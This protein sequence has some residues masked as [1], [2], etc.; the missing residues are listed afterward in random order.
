MKCSGKFYGMQ[1]L[2]PI[3]IALDPTFSLLARAPAWRAQ[4]LWAQ[5]SGYDFAFRCVFRPAVGRERICKLPCTHPWKYF[6]NEREIY[7]LFQESETWNSKAVKLLKDWNFE[8]CPSII[9]H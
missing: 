2:S 5:R 1:A 7:G 4:I 3:S 8:K 6:L 9:Q